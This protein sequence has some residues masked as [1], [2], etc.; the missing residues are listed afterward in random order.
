[1]SKYLNLLNK[2]QFKVVFF[3]SI[4]IVLYLALVPENSESLFDFEHFDKVKHAIVFFILSFL[5]NRSSSD[6]T[7]RVRN[8]LA[9]FGFGL[10]I[11][12]LQSFT[13][14][15]TVSL[16]DVLANLTGILLFQITYSLLKIWQKK[17]RSKPSS[18]H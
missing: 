9:L 10:L 2:N 18:S 8:I 16:G 13:G 11:E 7:K 14:Y 1:M 5:L 17:R 15:R 6:I 12:F 4:I 3:I